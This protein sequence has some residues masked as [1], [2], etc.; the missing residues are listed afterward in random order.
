[1]RRGFTLIELLVVIAIIAILAAILFP[2]FAKAREKARAASCLS[3]VKQIDLAYNMYLQDYDEL[4]TG[5]F[6]GPYTGYTWTEG[7][8]NSRYAWCQLILP[9]VKNHQIFL[10]PSY[11]ARYTRGTI[12]PLSSNY[13]YN[14]C[15]LGAD[16]P[17]STAPMLAQVD[18]PAETV[19]L[20]DSVCCGIKGTGSDPRNCLYIGPGQN[21]ASYPDNCHPRMVCHNGGINLAFVD[22]HA[23]FFNAQS[24]HRGPFWGRN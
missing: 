8:P 23:K 1:M 7:Q 17:R 13:G 19:L 21:T 18:S 10:C 15:A 5:R 6:I 24:I 9:Y 12:D 16:Q 22:G 3:N 4:F 14:L 20:G 2:V 11:P